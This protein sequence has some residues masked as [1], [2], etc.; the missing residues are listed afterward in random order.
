MLVAFGVYGATM[1]PGLVGIGDTPKLQFVGSV[2]GT[3]HSPGYPLYV[4]LSWAFSQLPLG[5]VAFRINLLSVVC[6]AAAVGV[7]VLVLRE[8]G[9][10]RVVAF[11]GAL[12]IGLGRLYWS[13]SILAEVYALNALLFS[14]VLLFLLR[15]SRTG[16][17]AD[18]AWA[19]AVFAAGLAHHLTLA[20]TAPALLLYAVMVDRHAINARTVTATAM[21]AVV[22]FGCYLFLWLRTYEQA[23]FLE[24]RA[25]SISDL[26]GIIS[27]RQFSHSLFRFPLRVLFTDRAALVGRWLVSELQWTG[28]LMAAVGTLWLA[29]TR[30]RDLVLLAGC[31]AAVITFVLNY[32]VYDVQVFLIIPM[33]AIGLLASIGAE[34]LFQSSAVRPAMVWLAI[35]AVLTLPAA[36]YRANVRFNNHHQHT[37]EAQYFEALFDALPDRS[38]IVAESYTFDH[39]ILYKLLAERAARGRRIEIIPAEPEVVRRY[40][41][42]GFTVFAFL[43]G[44]AELELDVPFAVA[45]L[46]LP[47]TRGAKHLV[48][49]EVPQLAYPVSVVTLGTTRADVALP[50]RPPEPMTGAVWRPTEQ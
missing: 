49:T 19:L 18:L 38:A 8:L 10:R 50:A 32:D 20:M 37:F 4:W 40:A 12:A 46:A 13:Q 43:K 14:G 29:V 2:L 1:Y 27:G 7:M 17:F 48:D 9:C 5:T 31:A 22:G 24:V 36:Q 41:A 11:S 15:W 47:S 39:M 28:I 45:D 3:P 44:R 6:G 21:A 16:E 34:A 30:R 35:A 23:P 25:S 33:I 42:S 26:V